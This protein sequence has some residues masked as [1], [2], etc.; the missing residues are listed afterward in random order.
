LRDRINFSGDSTS[1]RNTA[2]ELG[3]LWKTRN[4]RVVLIE[5][6]DVRCV[7]V[8]YLTAL[9]MYREEGRSIV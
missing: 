3:F 1:L 8:S 7:R 2:K 5:K 6:H 9:N 4:S